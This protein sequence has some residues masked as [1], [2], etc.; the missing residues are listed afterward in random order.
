MI[1][2]GDSFYLGSEGA[3]GMQGNDRILLT[4]YQYTSETIHTTEY[5]IETADF[6]RHF[7]GG[8][9]MN[10]DGYVYF[11]VADQ[12]PTAIRVVRVCDYAREPCSSQLQAVVEMTLI[13]NASTGATTRVCG[14][15]LLESFADINV[16]IVV[17]TLCDTESTH[18]RAYA[19][20]IE[21][22]EDEILRLV[23]SCNVVAAH[24]N[25]LPWNISRPCSQ[26]YVREFC[27]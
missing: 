15:H 26:F 18:N 27:S 2:I 22:I 21:D 13:C 20:W 11:L 16:P 7:Y 9:T 3:A 25:E 14:V 19:F 4:Q 17:V 24:N 10:M 8:F 1:A 12:A 23:Y 5:S 6:D